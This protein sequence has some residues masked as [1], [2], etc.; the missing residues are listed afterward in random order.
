MYWY[1]TLLSLINYIM[2]TVQSLPR[3]KI[4]FRKPSVWRVVLNSKLWNQTEYTKLWNENTEIEVNGELVSAR[5]LPQSKGGGKYREV[6]RKGDTVKF[7]YKKHIVMEGKCSSDFITGMR[8]QIHTC[9]TGATRPHA[10]KNSEFIWVDVKTIYDT[11]EPY[12]HDGQKTW[13]KLH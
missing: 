10:E 8:H 4:L 11:P 12:R 2:D 9:N 5:Q 3:P 1:S 7:V 6:P 13:R